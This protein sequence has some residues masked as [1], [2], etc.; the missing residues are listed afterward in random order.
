MSAYISGRN[1]MVECQLP[2]LK[3]ASSILVARSNVVKPTNYFERLG[4]SSKS[5]SSRLFS[6]N[7]IGN[8][9]ISASSYAARC[10]RVLFILNWNVWSS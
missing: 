8:S 7:R 1:S 2:K 6:L 5:F 9:E 4:S 3:V 10:D